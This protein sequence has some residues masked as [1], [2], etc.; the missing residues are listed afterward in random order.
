[1]QAQAAFDE[2]AAQAAKARA[3][4]VTAMQALGVQPGERPTWCADVC[5]GALLL[6]I[7][8]TRHTNKTHTDKTHAKRTIR[9]PG[10][11]RMSRRRMQHRLGRQTCSSFGGRCCLC[12]SS[13][14]QLMCEHTH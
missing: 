3:A 8:P 5:H 10:S 6:V 4:A 11:V 2:Y 12:C 13:G 7:D 1:M 9:N 14:T